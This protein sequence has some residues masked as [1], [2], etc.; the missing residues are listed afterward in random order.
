MQTKDTIR[1]KGNIKKVRKGLA[2][3]WV[4]FDF[5]SVDNQ[6]YVVYARINSEDFLQPNHLYEM[7]LSGPNKYNNYM[8]EEYSMVETTNDDLKLLLKNNVKGFKEEDHKKLKENVGENYLDVIKETP[9][10]QRKIF[11][12]YIKP[13][14]LRKTESFIE[15]VMKMNKDEKF[16]VINNIFNFYTKLKQKL[17]LT[18]NDSYLDFFD[19]DKDDHEDPYFV[20]YIELGF[21]FDV[22]DNFASLLNYSKTCDT[23]HNAIVYKSILDYALQVN[24]TYYNLQD[25]YKNWVEFANAWMLSNKLLIDEAS[26]DNLFLKSVNELIRLKKLVFEEKED[27]PTIALSYIREQEDF[28]FNKLISIKNKISK[29]VSSIED[30]SLTNKQLE[31]LNCALNESISIISGFPG[32]GKTHIINHIYESLID[33]KAYKKSEIEILTPTGRAAINIK[34]KSDNLPAKTIHNYLRI[35]KE[36][37]EAVYNT[38]CEKTKVIIIDEFSMVNLKIFHILLSHLSNLEKIIIVGDKDQLPCIGPGNIMRDL[39]SWNF[40][41]KT[42]LV[43]NQRT[44]SDEICEHFLSINNPK[45]KQVEI[46]ST[47]TIQMKEINSEELLNE[48]AYLYKTYNP[49]YNTEKMVT[50]IP[51]YEGSVGAKAVNKWLQSEK[52]NNYTFKLPKFKQSKHNYISIRDGVSFYLFDNVIQLVNDYEKNVFNGEIGIIKEIINDKK[53]VVEFPQGGSKFKTI[54]YSKSEIYTNLSLAYALTVHKFQGSEAPNVVIPIFDDYSRMLNKKLL[55]TAVSRAKE[56]LFILGDLNLYAKKTK[57]EGTQEK[58]SYL[59]DLIKK[60]EKI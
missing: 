2:N 28:I 38:D 31:A 22:V 25:L 44:E 7:V 36:D 6:I 58:N 9:K 47:N 24:D 12:Q 35:D 27:G 56:K 41:P 60:N 8:L 40:I 30:K 13:L 21:N 34:N 26:I 16:F 14:M 3:K 20:L 49:E 19:K 53:L 1:V 11:H 59:F 17:P 37:D 50:L 51:L 18:K 55:Y 39:C 46:G 15:E 23:R 4:L 33:Q 42:L 43:E 54:T 48:L 32:T 29:K 45:I 5:K 52:L 57:T 10:E